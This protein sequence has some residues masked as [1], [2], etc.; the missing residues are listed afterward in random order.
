MVSDVQCFMVCVY[1]SAHILVL[2]LSFFFVL[3]Y[4]LCFLFTCLFIFLGER[5]RRHGV[6]SVER[7]GI[8]E[9]MCI[10]YCMEITLV[11]T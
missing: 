8:W 10:I 11:S 9:E 6:G 5:E 4:P 7:W 3:F 1:M 2:F